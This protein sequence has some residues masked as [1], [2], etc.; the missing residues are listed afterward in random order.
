[1]DVVEWRARGAAG[2]RAK[3]ALL[4]THCHILRMSRFISD[5]PG[6]FRARV[7][8][9]RRRT[10][11][12]R[13]TKNWDDFDNFFSGSSLLREGCAGTLKHSHMVLLALGGFS[14]QN[15]RVAVAL[16]R[17]MSFDMI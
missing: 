2:R 13:T 17:C 9:V 8:G 11:Q 10:Q 3:G 7:C 6:S 12:A 5:A 14:S 15:R 4:G 16:L 1:M